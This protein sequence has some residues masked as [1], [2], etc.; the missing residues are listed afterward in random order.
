[1]YRV[2][3]LRALTFVRTLIIFTYGHIDVLTKKKQLNLI[4]EPITTLSVMLFQF[5]MRDPNVKRPL[6]LADLSL[7]LVHQKFFFVDIE[8]NIMYI[9]TWL[10]HE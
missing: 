1:M 10:K 2:L 4:L 8:R 6:Y 3:S 7:H 5:L 9:V